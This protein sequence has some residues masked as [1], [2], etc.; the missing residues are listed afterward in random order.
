MVRDMSLANGGL[1]FNVSGLGLCG[2]VFGL[3]GFVARD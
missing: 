3:D 1:I 2:V